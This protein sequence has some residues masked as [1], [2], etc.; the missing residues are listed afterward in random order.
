MTFPQGIDFRATSGF[1]VDP[2]N[3]TFDLGTTVY[4]TTSPQGNP[5]GWASIATLSARDR[6]A[7]IS[8]S[9]AG[10]VFTPEID[11]ST[12]KIGLP[13]AGAYSVGIA[14]GDDAGSQAGQTCRVFDGA[15]L[16][17]TLVP[18]N[19]TSP[20]GE[21]FDATGT[22]YTAAAWPGSNTLVSLTFSGTVASF[23]IGN[24]LGSGGN[25]TIAS[26]FIESAA[27]PPVTFGI[28]QSRTIFGP[29]SLTVPWYLADAAHRNP[30][31]RRR[32]FLSG[33]WRP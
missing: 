4:P 12:F 27:P 7:A 29:L 18:I 6:N 28:R 19:S 30:T 3:Y 17:A 15:T 10:I 23:T 11:A 25:C 5:I 8:P 1:V 31:L 33:I 9:L 16:L 20:A 14:M 26:I 21:F 32:R 22:L 13:S 24:T 2:T